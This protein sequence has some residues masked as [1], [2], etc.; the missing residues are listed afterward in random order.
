MV[1][2]RHASTAKSLTP[3]ANRS[4]SRDRTFGEVPKPADCPRM[5]W[6]VISFRHSVGGCRS[7]LPNWSA[8]SATRAPERRDLCSS[9]KG[10]RNLATNHILPGDP[11]L[12]PKVSSSVHRSVLRKLAGYRSRA[13]ETGS[14]DGRVFYHSAPVNWIR[15]HTD[16]PYFHSTRDGHKTSVELKPLAVAEN[17][18]GSIQAVL[19][20]ST[21]FAW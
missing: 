12:I 20:S 10:C 11:D 8:G 5:F 9:Q 7:R 4:Q 15:A 19:C 16:T 13:S 3:R 2:P 6:K 18:C 14:S 21:F 17:R 1:S